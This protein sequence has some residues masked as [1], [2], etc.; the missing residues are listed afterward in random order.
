[1]KLGN[2]ILYLSPHA[3]DEVGSAATLYKLIESGKNISL[4]VFSFAE[5]SVLPEYPKDILHKEL[6]KSLEVLGI[7]NLVSRNFPTRN[8][9]EHRQEILED[10]ISIKKS[11]DPD[12]VFTPS[13]YDTHQDHQVI[14]Q[15]AIRAFN[16]T[17]L[18]YEMPHK[19]MPIRNL[20][21]IKIDHKHLIKKMEAANCYESQK[22]RGSWDKDLIEGLARIRGKQVN[23]IYADAF[24]VI[25][26]KVY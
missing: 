11:L 26:M 1:M 13:T 6:K 14:T 23:E 7:S 25:K 19:I 22:F 24:E 3:D 21:Y 5:I 20:C 12:I 8:F 2:K 4:M 16:C 10:M 9:L 17:I 15:E 18:G